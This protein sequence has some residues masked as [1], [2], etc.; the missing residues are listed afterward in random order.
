MEDVDR[1]ERI[2]PDYHQTVEDLLSGKITRA[3]MFSHS[4]EGSTRRIPLLW[5]V[6]RMCVHLVSNTSFPSPPR[7]YRAMPKT[8]C[9]H[10][11]NE[12]VDIDLRNVVLLHNKFTSTYV[13]IYTE[14]CDPWGPAFS[15]SDD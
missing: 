12:V 2:I 8:P 6:P 13:K 7:F 15:Q 14:H 5:R 11:Y 4:K 1:R 3:Y 10:P 9:I